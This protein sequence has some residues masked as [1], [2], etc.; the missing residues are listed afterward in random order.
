MGLKNPRGNPNLHL[1]L[2]KYMLQS[3]SVC[4]VTLKSDESQKQNKTKNCCMEIG[5]SPPVSGNI[6]TN[7]RLL[8]NQQKAN[9]R[10]VCF[11]RRHG[12][13]NTHLGGS[14]LAPAAAP[15]FSCQ[16]HAQFPVATEVSIL[17]TSRRYRH[18]VQRTTETTVLYFYKALLIPYSD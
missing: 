14:N 8:I 2:W 12:F 16:V 18:F 5:S 7:Q 10:T 3:W 6:S 11:S 13:N 15:L 17:L 9:Y 4:L 1:Y